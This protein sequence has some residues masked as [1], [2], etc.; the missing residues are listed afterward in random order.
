MRG[1]ATLNV[2]EWF[3]Y[4]NVRGNPVDLVAGNEYTIEIKPML[5]SASSE[6]RSVDPERR[7]CKFEDEGVNTYSI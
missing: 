3:K 7:K 1:S 6:I 4:F 2:N 5:H